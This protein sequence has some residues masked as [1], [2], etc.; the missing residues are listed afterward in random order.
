MTNQ[1]TKRQKAKSLWDKMSELYFAQEALKDNILESPIKDAI[2][3]WF[4]SN[5][6]RQ[7][8]TFD[9]I[10]NYVNYLDNLIDR[11]IL[12]LRD[13]NKRLYKTAQLADLYPEICTK[14]HNVVDISIT[15][16]KYRLNALISFTQFLQ[17]ISNNK[18]PKMIAPPWLNS[19]SD[20]KQTTPSSLTPSQKEAFLKALMD[21]NVRDYLVIRLVMSTGRNLNKILEL[22]LS[23]VN[24]T[25]SS[26][27]LT[28]NGLPLMSVIDSDLMQTL[29]S[30]I[31]DTQNERK[32]ETVFITR[33][34]NPVFR[35]HFQ[36]VLD[37]ASEK[38]QL[39]FKATMTM[40]QWTEVS[41]SLLNFQ[42]KEKVLNEF[43]LPKLPKFLEDAVEG[44]V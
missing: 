35:T 15:E 24:F 34:G 40:L 5:P 1:F 16:K 19:E 43:K 9:T 8:L 39:G 28:E 29:K 13:Q 31:A 3:L 26:L 42:N 2:G 20:D 44:K 41:E 12:P 22:K 30:Y 21:I 37:L 33:T 38:A 23:N 6:V 14:L 11:K 10:R 25:F 27:K 4:L 36:H 32:D 7:Q 17:E 18:L